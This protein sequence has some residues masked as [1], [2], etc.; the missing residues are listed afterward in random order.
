MDVTRLTELLREAEEHHGQYEPTAPPHHWAGWYAYDGGLGHPPR[1]RTGKKASR[2]P[3]GSKRHS[4]PGEHPS[5]A[6]A[7][8]L[9][10]TPARPFLTGLAL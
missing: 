5:E 1:P 6:L 4:D 3:T 10:L 2:P 8:P 9:L 7:P